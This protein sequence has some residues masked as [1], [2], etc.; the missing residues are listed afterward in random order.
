MKVFG[1]H[2]IT[3]KSLKKKLAEA[4][5]EGKEQHTRHTNHQIASFLKENAELKKR[6]RNS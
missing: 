6:I 2:I 5:S 4:K 1:L 3:E